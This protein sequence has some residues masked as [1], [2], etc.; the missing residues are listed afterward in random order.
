M[1]KKGKRIKTGLKKEERNKVESGLTPRSAQTSVSL[2][3]HFWSHI[4]KLFHQEE[5]GSRKD[6]HA[7]GTSSQYAKQE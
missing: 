1:R 4:F 3:A 7:E 5:V 2:E 6:V